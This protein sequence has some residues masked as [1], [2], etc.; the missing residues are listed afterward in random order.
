[1]GYLGYPT[2]IEPFSD[3]PIKYIDCGHYHSLALLGKNID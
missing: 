1:M 2:L 3:I